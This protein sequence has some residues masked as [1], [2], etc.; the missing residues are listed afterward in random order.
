M[1]TKTLLFAL[2]LGLLFAPAAYCQTQTESDLYVLLIGA[3][4]SPD[5]TDRQLNAEIEAVLSAARK[6]FPDLAQKINAELHLTEISG[7]DFTKDNFD[8]A[9]DRLLHT[10]KQPN[11]KMML[12]I[13][14]ITHGTNFAD[15]TSPLPHWVLSYRPRADQSDLVSVQSIYDKLRHQ[16]QFDAIHLWVEACNSIADVPQHH[17]LSPTIMKGSPSYESLTQLLYGVK[18]EVTIAASYGQQAYPGVFYHSLW[19]TLYGV[20]I[21]KVEPCFDCSGGFGEWLAL[22]SKEASAIIPKANTGVSDWVQTPQVFVADEPYNAV[23]PVTNNSNN[24]K[25][26]VDLSKNNSILKVLSPIMPNN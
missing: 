16:S 9:I 19:R 21:S 12:I 23:V 8:L 4:E 10:R 25:D 11:R 20:E 18:A 17:A 13:S 6:D 5:M 3:N 24:N 26:K 22:Y 2:F 15:A 14:T 1:T 7:S